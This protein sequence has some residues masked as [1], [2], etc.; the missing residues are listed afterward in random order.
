VPARRFRRCP[1]T[2]AAIVRAY[3]ASRSSN[4]GPGSG[5]P[6][7]PAHLAPG[8][9]TQCANRSSTVRMAAGARRA[10]RDVIDAYRRRERAAREQ[11]FA[12]PNAPSDR[13]R[14]VDPG[15][16]L[17]RHF[18][19]DLVTARADRRADGGREVGCAVGPSRRRVA[20]RPRG[21]PPPRRAN[22]RGPRP[23]SVPPHCGMPAAPA[24]SPP[25][26]PRPAR[27][28]RVAIGH[29]RERRNARPVPSRRTPPRRGRE[30]AATLT[31]GRGGASSASAKPGDHP[32]MPSKIDLAIG[33]GPV[34]EPA[35]LW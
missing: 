23:P 34:C 16:E 31:A 32:S 5:V 28:P 14:P 20:L 3:N 2:L 15:G 9:R 33:E 12:G 26:S 6:A 19:A 7:D 21:P 27:R 29:P 35:V 13:M 10:Q 1:R 8:R 18:F 4:R 25:S 17:R 11:C 30:L 22:R 24:R